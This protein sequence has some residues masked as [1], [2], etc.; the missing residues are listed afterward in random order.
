[1]KRLRSPPQQRLT[2]Q[3]KN[4]PEFRKCILP[5]QPSCLTR[6]GRRWEERQVVN[7]EKGWNTSYI[8]GGGTDTR[9]KPNPG[10]PEHSPQ[11]DQTLDRLPPDPRP[12]TFLSLQCSFYRLCNYKCFPCFFKMYIFLQVSCQD[13]LK[14]LGATSLNYI[15]QRR[16]HP[17]FTVSIR[18]QEPNFCSPSY[19]TIS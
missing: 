7:K 3:G 15:H 18:R 10:W 19:R 11:L 2:L 5:L 16:Q 4:F 6:W 17:S 8:P 13:F 9:V 14:D 12:L 1:M